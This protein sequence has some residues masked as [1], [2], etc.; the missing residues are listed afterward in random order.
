MIGLEDRPYPIWSGT[1]TRNPAVATLAQMF[2]V[3]VKNMVDHHFDH[4]M[5]QP[6]NL[7]GL[8]LDNPTMLWRCIERMPAED[9]WMLAPFAETLR[10]GTGA[11]AQ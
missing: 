2:F 1:I 5:N 4:V 6:V 10:A 3:F 11:A 8:A 7:C 9:Y